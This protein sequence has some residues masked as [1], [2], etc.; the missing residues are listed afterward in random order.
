MVI[1]DLAEVGPSYLP[2][3]A[4]ADT[5]SFEASI[6]GQ[7]VIVNSGTSEYGLGAER[8]RQR[9]TPAHSTVTVADEDSS[10][11]WAGFRVARRA[12]VHDV[13]VVDGLAEA[14]HDGYRR[15]SPAIDHHRRWVLED[16]QLAIHDRV[17]PT[18]RAQAYYHLHPEVTAV[19]E[20]PLQGSL[21][22]QDGE[23]LRWRAHAATAHIQAGTWHPR[24][25][26]SVANKC[27]I[28][29]LDENGIASLSLCWADAG[30]KDATT[31]AK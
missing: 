1:A 26:A 29:T 17:T 30:K 28:L 22:L 6:F 12:H 11:V 8:L 18:A 16:T 7:R 9:G 2:G 15:L 31:I 13:H 27:L 24:F 23:R 19:T 10:E 14:R 4:H 5:L 25:G 20:G 21:I 3:H